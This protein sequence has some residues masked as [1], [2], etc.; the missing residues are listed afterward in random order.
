LGD[1]YGVKRSGQEGEKGA[2]V[3]GED[4]LKIRVDF[5]GLKTFQSALR[6]VAPDLA[7]ELKKTT[8]EPASKV[9]NSARRIVAISDVPS[10]W[11]R[12]SNGP[13]GWGDPTRK[14]WDNNKVRS[15]IKLKAGK[16]DRR[17]ITPL[18]Q[19]RN[20]SP[21]GAIYEF[22]KNAKTPQGV[23]FVRTINRQRPSRLIWRA[24]D[25]AGGDDVVRPAVNQAIKDV[26]A[27][28]NQRVATVQGGDRI[29]L[30]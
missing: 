21:A 1:G 18:W 11:K 19:I 27:K 2:Q 17:G 13:E 15:G 14:G 30:G 24:W 7:E 29:V 8:K 5:Y 16:R 3:S 26:E 20:D 23:S 6:Q 9:Y 4:G 12:R 25:E 10:G 22:A 28:F